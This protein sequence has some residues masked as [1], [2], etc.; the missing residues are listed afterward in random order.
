MVLRGGLS[1]LPEDLRDVLGNLIQSTDQRRSREAA[2]AEG[3]GHWPRRDRWL[4]SRSR[5]E[6]PVVEI[7]LYDQ[8]G[9]ALGGIVRM[10][11]SVEGPRDHVATR[12][13]FA[14]AEA[15]EYEQN[16][17][18]A[19]LNMLN[20]ALAVIKSKKLCGFY[21][22]EHE[23][24]RSTRSTATTCSMRT[25]RHEARVDFA[26]VRRTHAPDARTGHAL[27]LDPYATVIH[28]CACGRGIKVVTPTSPPEWHLTWGGDAVSL[29]PSIGNWQFPCRSHYWIRRN[30]IIWAGHA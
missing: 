26:R 3:G 10:T 24:R 25:R 23:L 6:D 30:R 28:L 22:F 8:T 21:D 20:V 15:D 9:S 27:R 13:F 29:Y 11:T 16:I 17:Q 12:I 7:H 19:D 18:I 4:H 1:N 5:C 14:D 2:V